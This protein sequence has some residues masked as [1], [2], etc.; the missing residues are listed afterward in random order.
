MREDLNMLGTEYNLAVTCFQVG[1]ILGPIPANLLLTW[2]PPR[3]LLPGLELLWGVLTIGTT[4][5][6]STHQLYPIRFLIGF[7][8]GSCF[9]GVQ[10]VLGSWYKRT[11][12][13]KR[14][15]IFTCAAYVGTMFSGYMQSAMIAGMNGKSGLAAW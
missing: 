15:A 14:T 5:V 8:E 1:Q 4:F 2:I 3:I 11:E 6:S 12:I 9:V 13:G 7:L 10:Y